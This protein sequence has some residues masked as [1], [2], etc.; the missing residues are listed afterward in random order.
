MSKSRGNVVNPDDQVKD[1]GADAVRLYLAFIGP[2]AETVAPWDS[3]GLNGV[4]HFLQRVW[5]LSEKVTGDRVQGTADLRM[6]H[7]TI[8]RVTEDIEG[9]KFNTAVA[10]MMEYINYLSRKETISKEEYKTFLLLLA[11]FAPHMTEELWNIVIRDS[12]IVKNEKRKTKNEKSWS[13]HKQSWPVFDNKYLEE[14]EVI[15]VVQ[16]N[17]KVRDNFVIGK[18]LVNNKDVVEKMAK[19]SEKV[20]KFLIGKTVKKTV[21]IPGKIISVVV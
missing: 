3:Q 7:K 2:Y 21:Y 4:Y 20:Q 5:T 19:E 13:I 14:D 11:P 18:D 8:K 10:G 17:G 12:S 6:M 9:S 15:I 16:V 1:Y